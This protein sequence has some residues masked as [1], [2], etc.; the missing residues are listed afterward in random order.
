MGT[1]RSR[2]ITHLILPNLINQIMLAEAYDVLGFSLWNFILTTVGYSP[3]LRRIQIFSA[4]PFSEV[5]C[6]FFPE[7]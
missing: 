2:Y 6:T 3:V 5:P 1:V 7:V 4:V